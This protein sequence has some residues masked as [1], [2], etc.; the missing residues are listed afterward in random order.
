MNEPLVSIV[1]P[2]FNAAGDIAE[3]IRSALDQTYPNREVIVV[4]DGSTDNSPNIIRSFGDAVR[5]IRVPHQGGAAARN[6]G[7]EAAR[8]GLIQLLDS[9][10]ILYPH[11]LEIQVAEHLKGQAE[12]TLTDWEQTRVDD[13]E[14]RVLYSLPSEI[15]D[16]VEF[17]LRNPIQIASPLHSRERLR[18]LGGFR[19]DLPCCQERDLHIRLA[20]SGVTFHRVAEPLMLQRRRAGSVSSDITRIAETHPRILQ[21]A[22]EVLRNS[23]R[24]T[25][26]RARAFAAFRASDIRVYIQ[27]GRPADA[28]KCLEEARRMHPSG[29]LDALYAKPATR[30][31]ARIVGPIQAERIILAKRALMRKRRKLF[32][33]LIT[34]YNGMAFRI[35]EK[36]RGRP[37]ALRAPA[38]HTMAALEWILRAEEATEH[39]GVAGH[40]DVRNRAWTAAYPETT[41]YIIGTLLRAAQALPSQGTILRAAAQRM[42]HW[43]AHIQ[44]NDGAFQG[45]D[46]R[47]ANPKPAVF[48]TGQALAGLT[49]LIAAKLDADGRVSAAAAKAAAWMIE[50]QDDDGAWRRGVSALTTE[51]VHAYYTF[52][53]WPLARYGR[54][55]GHQ[56]L[57][58]AAEN[59]AA[60]VLSLR[61]ANGWFPHMNFNLGEDPLLHTVA[62]TL[63]GLLEIGVLCNREDFVKAATFASGRIRDLQDRQTGAIPGRLLAPYRPAA[64]WTSTTGNSQMALIWFRLADITGDIAWIEP[65]KKA[66]EFNCSIQ[67]LEHP[68]P[69]RRGGVRGSYPGHTGYGQYIY[70]NWAQKFHADALM[71]EMDFLSRTSAP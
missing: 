27:A 66:N 22:Y 33:P 13:P 44:M 50:Q 48:N 47:M 18:A 31:L 9:D 69:G 53:A 30:A 25:D 61:D 5:S 15:M 35:E 10:D 6:R 11:K 46:V 68:D 29:G 1:I 4:D 3:A 45:G 58:R 55:A 2:C 16:P 7:I 39:R 24:L 51:P 21:P 56:S 52:A 19:E 54:L 36:L 62:Y 28:A 40:Y 70:M 26:G 8:G 59:N 41:G 14:H 60:W 38:E 12:I 57:V 23:G 43:L 32:A 71:A 37:A 42:G 17:V 65:A 20:C 64:T 49:D 67:D 63:Q 34:R